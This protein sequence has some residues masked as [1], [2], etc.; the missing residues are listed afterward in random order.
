MVTVQDSTGR[1]LAG[2]ALELDVDGRGYA[3]GPEI[4]EN[5]HRLTLTP[6]RS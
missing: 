5:G 4:S 6:A 3:I 1:Q 2:L